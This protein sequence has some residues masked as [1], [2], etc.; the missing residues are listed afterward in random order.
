MTAKLINVEWRLLRREPVA[1]FWGVAFPMVL[2]VVMGLASSG[3]DKGLGGVSL[4]DAYVPIV[5]AFTVAILAVSALP[6]VVATY[7]EE[8]ILRRLAT[9]PVAPAR[10]L[11][12][13]VVVNLGVCIT[14]AVG[15]LVIA[16]VAFGVG[17]PGQPVGFVL[18]YA[19]TAA[20]LLGIGML[21]AA[22][23]PSARTANAVGAIV[24]LPM[25]FFAGLWVPRAAM[26]PTLRHI[27]DVTPLGAG[28]GA[29]Q[30]AM[31]GDF[32]RPLHLMALVAWAA[33]AA[34]FAR[35]LFRWD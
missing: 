31:R 19:L 17:L 26:G 20:A 13:Q 7:R 8:G 27:S 23:T 10:V 35:T 29:L 25:M 34:A 33:I 12:A 1:L 9:T 32:P 15:V 21:V 5:I 4:V 24:F 30:A 11:G 3:P 22:V 16:R 14:A 2:L 18:A 6:T 28:V